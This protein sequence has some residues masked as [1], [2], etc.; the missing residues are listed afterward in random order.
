MK[1][2]KMDV[3]SADRRIKGTS[4]LGMDGGPP[5]N[6]DVDNGKIIRLRP[7]RYDAGRDFESLSPWKISAHGLDFG[8]PR[9]SLPSNMGLSFKTRVYSENRVRYPLKRVDWDPNGERNPQNRGKSKYV[10]ITWD[11]AAQLIADELKRVNR[12]YGP[13]A[14]LVE[15][16]M[17]A[18]GKHIYCSHGC[19]ARLLSLM[20][21]Y[22]VQMRNEDSWEG[23]F[24]GAKHVWGGT[25]V[26]EMAPMTNLY[27]DIARH[28]QMLLFWGCDPETTPNAIDGHMASRLCYYLHDLGIK[29]VYVC[30]DLNYGAAVHADKWIPVLP[31]TD[32]ALYLAIM[33]TWLDEGLYDK[34]YVK[35]HVVGQEEFFDYILGKED[36]VPKTPEWA[37]PKCGVSEWTIKALARAWAKYDTSQIIGNG[38]G[39]IRGPYSHEPA[40]LAAIALGMQGLG[41]PGH[42]QAKMIEWNLDDE[43]GPIPYKTEQPTRL[44]GFSDMVRPMDL[45]RQTY[46]P[47]TDEVAEQALHLNGPITAKNTGGPEIDL[48]GFATRKINVKGDPRLKELMTYDDRGPIQAIPRCLVAQALLEGHADWWGLLTFGGPTSQQWLHFHYPGKDC[49]RVHMIWTDAPCNTT[50]WNDGFRFAKACRSE[51]IECM[52]AQHMT[53]ENDCLMADIILPIVTEKEMEDMIEDDGGGIFQAVIRAHACSDPVGESLNDFEA[54]ARVAKALGEDYYREYTMGDVYDNDEET[55]CELFYSATGLPENGLSYK[56]FIEKEGGIHFFRPSENYDKLPAGLFEF[57]IDPENHP[58]STPTGKLEFTSSALKQYFPDDEERPPH[59]KWI[60]KGFYHDENISSERAKIYPLLCIS[61]HGHW[62]MH[63][64]CDDIKWNREVETMKIRCED[65]YQYEPVW[66]HPAE[67]EKRGIKHGDIVKVFNERGIVLCGAFVT[68][69]LIPGAAYVDHGARF[70]PIDPNG[71][72]RGGAINLITPSNISSEHCAG[73][74]VTGF[75][76][77]VQKVTD[78]EMEEWKRKYPEAFARK[79]DKGIG[80][81][82]DGWM[83]PETGK[84]G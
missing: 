17:H 58:L 70:D 79:V 83:I 5:V 12:K 48:G 82:L 37:S 41:K 11:E 55:L 62:R 35:T 43:Y 40:R 23:W 73:M 25:A 60:E 68:E 65:G 57:Y 26:G 53:L 50:C 2:V 9:K 51:E 24:W 30:P 76:V 34:E 29:A 45:K 36:G 74:V 18:E 4:F 1:A 52:V 44:P 54:V 33:Y 78:A 77:E 75:L 42:H 61:N 71:I 19:Q 84:E 21:G 49:S 59:P 14:V 38:G 3:K 8:P 16:D 47:V 31:C 56:D 7:Y 63:A 32:A 28:S 20:G 15:A 80:L 10:R 27:P 67:A 39:N 46:F 6:V 69:R 64:Q 81:C 13:E 22:T 66:L 72:D